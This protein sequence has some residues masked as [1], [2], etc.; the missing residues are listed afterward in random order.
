MRQKA[1]VYLEPREYVRLCKG[2]EVELALTNGHTVA[3]ALDA[4]VLAGF[5]TR[6]LPVSDTARRTL[7]SSKRM[8]RAVKCSQCDAV[9]KRRG[10]PQHIYKAHTVKGRDE[11]RRLG[12]ESRRLARAKRA[13]GSAP[14]AKGGAA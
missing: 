6:A 9:V 10:L 4:T 1:T 7:R 3:L 12:R 2:H 13:Y 5:T 11:A 14:G 8:G